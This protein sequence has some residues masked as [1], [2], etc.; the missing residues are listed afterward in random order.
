MVCEHVQVVMQHM[1]A[2]GRT[3]FRASRGPLTGANATLEPELYSLVRYALPANCAPRAY[4]WHA[5]QP[6]TG[7]DLR[8]RCRGAGEAIV[9]ETGR[10]LLANLRLAG[11]WRDAS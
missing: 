7:H 1:V 5:V 8:P 10:L 9:A 6:V 3:V 2:Q 11:A 4:S